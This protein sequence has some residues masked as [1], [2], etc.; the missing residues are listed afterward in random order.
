M[1]KKLLSVLLI[2][3]TACLLL[4]GCKNNVGTPEYNAVQDT[5]T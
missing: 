2:V 4:A 3:L 1:K 5:E